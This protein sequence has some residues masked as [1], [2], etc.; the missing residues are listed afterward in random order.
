MYVP[1][2]QASMDLALVDD[3]IST[4]YVY[5]QVGRILNGQGFRRTQY[6]SWRKHCSPIRCWASMFAIF[7]M[8]PF[9]LVETTIQGL[10]M[11]QLTSALMDVTRKV[12]LGQQH[13]RVLRG[14]T[15]VGLVSQPVRNIL[16]RGMGRNLITP[17][18]HHLDPLPRGVRNTLEAREVRNWA[19]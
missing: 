17:E 8:P 19:Y 15:P 10:S 12:S 2:K 11:Y 9:G 3:F 5:G 16:Q 6:S 1:S 18:P 7:N 14:L 13:S 4:A